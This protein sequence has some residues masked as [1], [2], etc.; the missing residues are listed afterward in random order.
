MPLSQ[1]IERVQP[2]ATMAISAKA[3]AM[4]REGIDVIPLSAGEPDFDTPEH[5]KAAGI[6][7]IEEGFTKYTS[8]PSGIV[9]LKEAVCRK[10]RE[11]NGLD[12]STD[13]V[14][15]NCGAKHSLYLAVAAVLN[16]GDEMIVPTPYWVTFTEQPKLVGA[17]SA[18]VRTRREDGLKLTPDA[19]R[20]A[21]TPRSRMLLLNSPS[22]PS[23][24][25]YTR[26]ELEQLAAVAV[27]H[28]IYVLSDEIYEKLVYDGAEHVSIASLGEEIKRLAI[29]VNG[30]SKAYAMTGWRIGYAA[31]GAQVV[32]AMDKAQSQTVSHPT[33][34]SQKAALEAL[35]GPQEMVE[36]MR[37]EYD[38]RRRYITSRLNG[39]DGVEC[40]MPLGAFYVYPD[41]SSYFGSRC[42]GPQGPGRIEDCTSLC[43]YL[44][45]A[46]KVAC[47]PGAG[48]GTGEHI[49]L[50]YATSMEKIAAAMDRIEAALSLLRR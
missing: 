31:A 25:V 26:E 23:G 28:G 35:T 1:F 48:F 22:N 6:R 18:V 7:A 21:I 43:E 45:E 16:P 42:E 44:L 49:R 17:D 14:I 8:P 5:I 11:D 29:V 39:L 30:A 33:S 36:T 19:L 41:M 15:V 9:E 12:Y 24:C 4:K 20:A 46:G 40:P 13:E 2:S 38:R 47:V 27:E 50:S 34:M 3:A 37:R 10:F 32:A